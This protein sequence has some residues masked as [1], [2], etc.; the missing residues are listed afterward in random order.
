MKFKF[1]EIEANGLYF[2]ISSSMFDLSFLFDENYGKVE[3]A[4]EYN[5]SLFRKERIQR[6]SVHFRKLL[7][8]ITSNPKERIKDLD[9]I[10]TSEKEQLL[11]DFNKQIHLLTGEDNV[12]DLFNHQA[13]ANKKSLALVYEGRELTYEELDNQSDR[14]ANTLM[15]CVALNREDIV[16]V[17]VDDPVLSVASILA[18]M[19]TGAAYLPIAPIPPLKE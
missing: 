8:S 13:E 12:I 4:I 6:M 1:L 17:V 11:F 7:E 14:I 19:K 15:E 18:V 3:F 2:S 5:T 9:I 16:A 10:P